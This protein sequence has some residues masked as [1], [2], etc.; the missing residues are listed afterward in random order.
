VT[1]GQVQISDKWYRA[2]A[3]LFNSATGNY[4]GSAGTMPG[5]F[6]AD[7]GSDE[8]HSNTEVK[9]WLDIDASDVG[10]LADVA[11]SGSIDDVS[12]TITFRDAISGV[13]EYPSV[14]TYHVCLRIPFACT[15]IGMSYRTSTGSA[16]VTVKNNGTNV[17]GLTSLTANSSGAWASATS[18]ASVS[19]GSYIAITVNSLSSGE[20][21]AFAI[22]IERSITL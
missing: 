5:N 3:L 18:S 20:N 15:I 1:S 12:G 10:G 9:S 4:A 2:L 21:F 13:I 22:E 16:N 14:K 7:P 6:T 19:L 8:R 17:G 11:T